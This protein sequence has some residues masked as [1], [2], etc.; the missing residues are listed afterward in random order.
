LALGW[1]SPPAAGLR[2]SSGAQQPPH[3][4]LETLGIEGRRCD[5][6]QVMA[7]LPSITTDDLLYFVL[8]RWRYM[9]SITFT[10]RGSLI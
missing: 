5:R 9:C 1:D 10:V 4:S 6:Y 2:A 7:S 3:S 8:G